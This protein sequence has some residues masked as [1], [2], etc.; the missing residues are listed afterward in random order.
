MKPCD[1]CGAP[2]DTYESR[3]PTCN[4]CR[5]AADLAIDQAKE[6]A[7]LESVESDEFYN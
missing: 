1:N 6:R 4:D 2:H 5:H 3:G 7:L